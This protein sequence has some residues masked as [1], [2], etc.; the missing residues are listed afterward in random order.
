MVE[1]K[2]GKIGRKEERKEGVKDR[3]MKKDGRMKK[4]S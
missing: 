2:E 1:M 3:R 4:E